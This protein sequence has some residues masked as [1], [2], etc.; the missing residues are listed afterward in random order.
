MPRHL[1]PSDLLPGGCIG[2]NGTRGLT[3][4]QRL[5]DVS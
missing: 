4:G 3:T 1:N 2:V 5:L